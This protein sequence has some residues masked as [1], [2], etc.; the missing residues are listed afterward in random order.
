KRRQR[1]CGP[2]D[3]APKSTSVM[4]ADAVPPAEGNI[5]P[6][7]ASRVAAASGSKSAARTQGFPR[8]LGGPR[9]SSWHVPVGRPE[10]KALASSSP[11][12]HC[13]A[14]YERAPAPRGTDERRRRS[15][16]GRTEE[17]G[18]PHS[19][20]EA[21]ERMPEGAGGGKGNGCC[22]VASAARQ[23]LGQG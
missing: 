10:T 6:R 19:T 9:I 18:A 13:S 3:R 7:S 2:R 4:L 8:N 22:G 1:A 5:A 16:T 14:R 11:Q 21:S 17:V 15:E 20:D 23:H 12:W